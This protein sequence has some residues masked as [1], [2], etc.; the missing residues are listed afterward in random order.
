M[1]SDGLGVRLCQKKKSAGPVILRRPSTVARLTARLP[2]FLFLPFPRRGSLIVPARR[3][4]ACGR[5][6]TRVVFRAD[7]PYHLW[8]LFLGAFG[9]YVRIVKLRFPALSFLY[10]TLARALRGFLHAL[11]LIFFS[12]Y[13]LNDS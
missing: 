9:G 1:N 3:G 11:T 4:R 2:F 7:Q 8:G 13:L 6:S 10:R 12:N 5:L